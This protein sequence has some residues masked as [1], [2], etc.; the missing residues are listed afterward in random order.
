MWVSNL[1]KQEEISLCLKI[2]VFDIHPTGSD[3]FSD[4]ESFMQDLS[5]ADLVDIEGELVLV[6]IC[7][8]GE[9]RPCIIITR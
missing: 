7:T 5:E 4:T 9:D 6:K 2:T 3:L 8:Q 1:R